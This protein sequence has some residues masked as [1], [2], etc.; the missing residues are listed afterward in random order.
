[1]NKEATDSA[2]G[3]AGEFDDLRRWVI[4]QGLRQAAIADLLAGFSE[5]LLALG[6]PL[7]RSFLSLRIL[8]PAYG[9]NVYRWLRGEGITEMH[10][11]IRGGSG[12]SQGFLDGPFGMML[13]DRSLLMRRRLSGP[14]AV[15]DNPVFEELAEIGGTDYL[16]VALPFDGGPDYDVNNGILTSWVADHED[17]FTDQQ[18][19]AIR[20]LLPDLGLAVRCRA[21]YKVAGGLLGAY[22][23]RDTGRRILNGEI[24]LGAAET[25]SAAIMYA[26]LRGFTYMTER[27]PQDELVTML[28][29]YLECMVKPVEERGG[30]VLKYMGDGLLAGLNITSYGEVAACGVLLDAAEE[31]LV[32]IAEMNARRS[33][34][35]LPVME[36]D[37]A[38]HA[39]D[40][41]YGNIGT[42]ERLDYTVIGPAVNESVRIEAKCD[43]LETHLLTSKSFAD[44]AACRD[45]RLT[46]FGV[47]DL[48]GVSKP[49]ELFGLTEEPGKR[50]C[51]PP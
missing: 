42:Q 34:E 2:A 27:L 47:H 7:L 9:G 19:A 22:M 43:E 14:D 23:G 51:G 1:M 44:L 36:L 12:P 29:E 26:D 11:F 45:G 38:L 16:A 31:S 37:I 8:H 48:R 10:S 24:G 41:L 3:N 49:Q 25:I 33:A 6:F 39:G 21:T 30:E 5:R 40:V 20:A 28:N 18:V 17:G 15:I 32:R 13:R 4:A 35:G 50:M 46:S